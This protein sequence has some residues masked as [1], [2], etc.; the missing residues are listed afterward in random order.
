MVKRTAKPK[1][2]NP[3]DALLIG[4][5]RGE[6]WCTKCFERYFLYLFFACSRIGYC[7]GSHLTY[8]ENSLF[9]KTYNFGEQ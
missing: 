4:Q 5:G 7:I 1:D 6:G 9:I 3:I 8:R 2:D